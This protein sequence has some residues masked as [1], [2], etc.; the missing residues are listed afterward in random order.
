MA[1]QTCTRCGAALRAGVCPNGHPQRVAR[2]RR[3]GRRWGRAVSL[4]VLVLLLAGAAYASFTW[5]PRRV[6]GQAVQPTSRA[7]A[8]SLEAYR[9][10]L[11]VYPEEARPRAVQV[12]SAEVLDRVASARQAL[13]RGQAELQAHPLPNLPVIGNRPPISIAAGVHTDM[14]FFYTES[15]EVVAD[16]ESVA[17]YLTDLAP[18]LP[19]LE[20]L[21]RELGNP[22]TP[23][24]IDR[25]AAGSLAVANQLITDLQAITPPE[26]MGPVHAA[27][28]TTSR[29]IRRDLRD[30]DRGSRQGRSPVLRALI[31]DVANR[32]RAYRD[33]FA[34]APGEAFETSLGPTIEA[35]DRSVRRIAD[36]LTALRDDYEV[37]ALTIPRGLM[38]RFS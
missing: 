11:D 22:R 20:N 13:G 31:G 18:T 32:I 16:L 14:Q 2:H 36:G 33:R 5:Y 6:T 17:R 9:A 3:R 7:F 12:A 29:A 4:A 28:Q 25:A 30:I 34:A 35:L 24:E 1:A 21:R 23:G 27:L 15:L 38:S 26:E 10:T 8:S 37:A 19:K